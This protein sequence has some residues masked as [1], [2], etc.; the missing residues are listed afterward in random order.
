MFA[1]GL[2]FSLLG[3]MS[4]S[5]LQ[6]GAAEGDIRAVL[7][8]YH[9][10]TH[11][12]SRLA[13][14][15][16]DML[17]ENS[18]ENCSD[19]RS[20]TLQLPRNARVTSLAM[21]LSDGCALDGVV[22]ALDDAVKS[23]ESMAG[24]GK[25]AALLTAWDMAN[26]NLKVSM[27]PNGTT[28]VVLQYQELLAQ[29][30]G[31]VDFQVPLFPGTSVRKL[32]MDVSVEDDQSGILEF[33]V[34]ADDLTLATGGETGIEKTDGTNSS[35][36]HFERTNLPTDSSLPTLLPVYFRPGPMPDS[37]LM[38]VDGDCFT[39]LFSP[40]TFLSTAGSMARKIVF[41]I[42][43]SGSMSGQKLAD[44]KASFAAMIDTLDER[45]TLIVQPFSDEGTEKLWGPSPA[46]A[47]NKVGAK[48][49]VLALDTIGGTNLNQA[50]LDG[51]ANVQSVP[52]EVAPVLVILTDGQGNIGPQVTARNILKA[53]ADGKVKIFSLAFG[54]DAD[55]DLLSGIAIQNRG[56][57]VRIYEG[58]GDAVAQ[59]ELFYQQELGTIMLSDIGITYDFGD[60]ITISESTSSSF[61]VLASGSEIVV[62]GKVDDALSRADGILRSTVV[63]KSALGR[64]EWFNEYSII[65]DNTVASDCRS[66]FAQ[67][68]IAELLEYRDAARALGDELL[69][70]AD[71]VAD[72]VSTSSLEDQA[73]KIAL[74][75][76]LVWPGLTA[77]VTLENASCEQHAHDVCSTSERGKDGQDNL[78]D[79]ESE[80]AMADS[81]DRT[82]TK[83]AGGSGRGY[84]SPRVYSASGGCTFFLSSSLLAPSA[85]LAATFL[86]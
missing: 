70:A 46:T 33:D 51:I 62:R 25:A 65:R 24:D 2:L 53:N 86:V 37:G 52:E 38:L 16:I 47:P 49:F 10:S 12:H 54:F 9:V 30:L 66:S 48:D 68:R 82:M 57:A 36:A 59:M 73:R 60:N 11:V 40:S 34:V 4:P 8:S 43:V 56:R 79:N 84:S 76:H 78:D 80:E 14:T 15:S 3:V 45:D 20:L 5:T 21:N 64:R 29:K 63:A 41:V 50:F 22:R 72:A 74:D 44:A 13:T 19:S 28:T 42:D 26:Y 85:V 58:F 23:Y 77:L 61:P 75:A 27:P 18:H 32:Q 69:Q 83:N 1:F 7:S 67:A 39:H 81:G 6:I 55:M 17:F 31:K 35:S 71:H